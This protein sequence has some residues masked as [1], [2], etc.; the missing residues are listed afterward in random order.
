MWPTRWRADV[1]VAILR[2]AG[3]GWGLNLGASVQTAQNGVDIVEYA[4]L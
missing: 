1:L 2:R 3:V 4:V